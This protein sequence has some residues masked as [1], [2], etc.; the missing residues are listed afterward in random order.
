MPNIKSAKKRHRQSLERRAR[1]RSAKSTLKTAI[2]K[3]RE[4]VEAKKFDDAKTLY[5][6]LCK[7]LDQTASKKIIHVNKAS[8]TKSRLSLY[9]KKASTAAA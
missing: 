9:L 7:L 6:D 1:N 4:T 5:L 2:K 8:R 3:L